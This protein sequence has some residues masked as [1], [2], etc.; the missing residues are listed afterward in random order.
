ME[1]RPPQIKHSKSQAF[2]EAKGIPLIQSAEL[3]KDELIGTGPSSYP[4]HLPLH[5]P[6]PPLLYT[7]IW[8]FGE[9]GYSGIF[10]ISKGTEGNPG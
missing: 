3:T 4:L 5:L 6:P 2:L 7:L 9:V 8:F 1:K 10:M